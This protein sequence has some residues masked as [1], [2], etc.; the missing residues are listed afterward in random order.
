MEQEKIKTDWLDIKTRGHVFGDDKKL[1]TLDYA[2]EFPFGPY[3]LEQFHE[4]PSICDIEEPMKLELLNE[5]IASEY[6][7]IWGIKKSQLKALFPISQVY[8]KDG[9]LLYI[10]YKRK[11]AERSRRYQ[12]FMMDDDDDD[13]KAETLETIMPYALGCRIYYC[14]DVLLDD[15]IKKSKKY[16]IK[17]KNKSKVSLVVSTKSGLSTVSQ[18]LK[19]VDLDIKS[20]Y[21]E[22]FVK[23]HNKIVS[24]LNEDKSKGLVLLHGIPGTGK[25]SYIKYLCGQIKKEIIFLPPFLAENISGPDFIPFLLE[26]TD[27]ILIIEDAEKIVLDRDAADSTS[28]QSVAN[29]LNMTD[30]ILSDCL[31]IQIIA[32]F[33]TNRDRIDKALLRKGRL[34]AEWKFDSLDVPHSNNLLKDLGKEYTTTKPMTLTEI[35]NLEEELNVVQQ[36]QQRIGFKY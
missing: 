36:E 6:N 12:D 33:N 32:T 13:K 4:L 18:T 26:H 20:N 23:I 2:D 14:R 35:Y 22:D 3:F 21:G 31:S 30:G 27:S 7:L 9:I 34:I 29:L 28:R 17:D 1:Y 19:K 10:S 24:K 5:V 11:S 15:F 16:I 25:T 8:E